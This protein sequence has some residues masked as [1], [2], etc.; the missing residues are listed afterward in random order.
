MKEITDVSITNTTV[1]G[2]PQKMS[3][4]AV[5]QTEDIKVPATTPPQNRWSGKQTALGASG[6]TISVG[7]VVTI[8]V[9]FRVKTTMYCHTCTPDPVTISTNVTVK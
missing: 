1:G 8:T 9:T 7:D 2:G 6:G 5:A 4:D 3:R